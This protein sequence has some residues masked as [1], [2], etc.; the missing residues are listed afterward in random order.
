MKFSTSSTIITY[1]FLYSSLLVGYYLGENSTGGSIPDFKMK[2]GVIESFRDDFM[3]S[4]LK[5]DN[6]FS[7]RH[8]PLMSIVLSQILKIGFDMDAVRFLHMH[9]VLIIILISYKCFKLK[10]QK[11]NRNILILICGAFFLSPTLRSLSIWPDSRLLGLLFFICSTFFYLKFLKNKKFKNCIYSNI[12]LLISSYF[13]PNF[14][15]FF[16]FFFYNYFKIFKFSEKIIIIIL[17][18][19]ILSFPMLYYV[20]FLDINFLTTIAISSID[21]STRIN[22]I[23]KILIIISLIFFY[24]LPL[25]FDKK[26]VRLLLSNFKIS[27]VFYSIIISFLLYSQ[28][29]YLVNFTGGGIF[30]KLSHFLFNNNYFFLLI[31]IIALTI[32]LNI[33]KININN[34]LLFFLLVLSNPQLTIYHKYYDPLLILLL[35]LFVDFRFD[36]KKYVNQTYVYNIYIFYFIFL[37]LNFGRYFIEI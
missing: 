18:N 37:A 9:L 23:N 16:I 26:I 28:F 27:D 32:F 4:L 30:L 20:F 1:F 17:L 21:F 22:P 12:F 29:N 25:L 19:I 13:S 35:L 36:I 6:L 11:T 15:I 5:Y 34:F 10:F 8:S 2:M 24:M 14:S 7:D 31:I 3:N 33:F